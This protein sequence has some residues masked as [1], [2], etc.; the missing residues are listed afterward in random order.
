MEASCLFCLE[1]VKQ[2]SIQNPIGCQCRIVAHTQCFNAWYQQKQ[3]L[4]CPICH[5]LA[6]PNAVHV[7]NIRIVF[8]DTSQRSE[9]Q[10]RFRGHEK[11]V[12]FCCCLLMGW[13]IGFTIIDLIASH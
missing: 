5:T 12:A 3:Q 11:A 4:E 2:D 6:I 10:R 1:P 13:A 9:S 7:D 8:V